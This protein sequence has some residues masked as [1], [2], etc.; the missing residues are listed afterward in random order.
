MIGEGHSG[1][2]H[3]PLLPET[4]KRASNDN[5]N[6]WYNHRVEMKVAITATKMLITK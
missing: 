3:V 1:G 6:S 2:V 5:E 4:P